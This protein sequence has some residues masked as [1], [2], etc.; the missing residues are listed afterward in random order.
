MSKDPGTERTEPLGSKARGWALAT[1]FLLLGCSLAAAWN[2]R[3]AP[4]VGGIAVLV[5][6]LGA[7]AGADFLKFSL[8]APGGWSAEA[9]RLAAEMATAAHSLARVP[10]PQLVR[11]ESIPSEEA[12]GMP[13]ARID[14]E[15]KRRAEVE[16]LMGVAAEWGWQMAH[17]GFTGPPEPV[18]EWDEDGYPRILYGQSWS[19]SKDALRRAASRRLSRRSE[20]PD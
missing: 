12:V 4:T 15:R 16:H 19:Q 8:K 9:E 13:E 18:V 3:S 14:E 6:F 10:E 17:I 5:V 1:A 7:L 11:P 2:L 20:E